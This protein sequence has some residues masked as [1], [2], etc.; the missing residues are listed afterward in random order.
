ML[1]KRLRNSLDNFGKHRA[2][3]KRRRLTT[4]QLEAR[5]LLTTFVVDYVGDASD[6]DY[7]SGNFSLREAVEQANANPGADTISFAAGLGGSTI[8]LSQGELPLTEAV[9][10]DASSLGSGVTIDAQNLS[11]VFNISAATGDFDLNGVTLTNGSTSGPG[12]AILSSTSGELTLTDSVVSDSSSTSTYP[13][14]GGIR[15]LGAVTVTRST[16]SG[17]S[18]QGRGGGIEA[19]GLLTVSESE[20]RDNTS[21][22]DGGGLWGFGGIVVS[23]S[24]LRNNHATNSSASG[25]AIHAQAEDVALTRSSVTG[26]SA[27]FNGGG[28]SGLY[29]TNVV[30]STIS[31]N[32]AQRGGGIHAYYGDLTVRSSTISGNAATRGGGIYTYS[33]SSALIQ[34]TTISNNSGGGLFAGGDPFGSSQSITLNHSTV[35]S[36]LVGVTAERVRNLTLNHTI[37]ADN[38]TDL[39]INSASPFFYVDYSLIGDTSSLSGGDLSSI[40]AGVGNLFDVSA[41]LGPLQDNGGPTLTHVPLEGSLVINAGDPTLTA[42][43]DD[44][45]LYDQRGVGFDR[46]H[47]EHIDIGAVEVEAPPIIVPSFDVVANSTE[48]GIVAEAAPGDALTFEITGGADAGA[49]SIDSTTG[50][51]TFNAAPD[52]DAPGDADQDN[53]YEVVVTVTN[54]SGGSGSASISIA[55]LDEG[56]VTGFV[57]ADVDN[58]GI[59]DVEDSPLAN[60]EITLIESGV[61]QVFGTADDEIFLTTTDADGFYAFEDVAAGLVRVIETGA[62]SDLQDGIDTANGATD[63]DTVN[64]QFTFEMPRADVNGMNFAERANE[65]GLKSGDTASIGF[66]QNKH[67]QQLINQLDESGALTAWLL[68]NFNNIF[69]QADFDEYGGSVSDFY[70]SEFFKMKLK[71]TPKVDAQ[72]M[73]TALATFATSSSLSNGSGSDFGF[74]LTTLGIGN[75]VINVGDSGAAFGTADDTDMT[76]MDVLLA[77]NRLTASGADALYDGARD[78][79]N[80]NQVDDTLGSLGTLDD[81]EKSL[82]NLA[83]RVYSAIN[84]VGH[85]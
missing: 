34:N 35:T 31:G 28:T 76:I 10:L 47:D 33:E 61:D 41:N 37:L 43:V 54:S 57:F 22:N 20:I 77:T 73:A 30:D 5:N 85:I 69:D 23:D 14:G 13:G 48:V 84:E 75:I 53:T 2:G 39:V 74:N 21:R 52:Y 24:A 62:P 60:V 46:V 65:V 29:R 49:F 7:S 12:G 18:S 42:G 56:D 19:H 4:E 9:S 64:D 8:A 68:G 44:V 40:Q 58:D 6:G 3:R 83:N 27:G 11:R 51:L 59:F 50:L 16:I 38:T 32:S 17:N 36:N 1:F 78:L 67:G 55:V 81:F 80:D 70:K 66:W 82:R 26:N 71:G 45:P 72:F 25:G 63:L 15:A 79:D